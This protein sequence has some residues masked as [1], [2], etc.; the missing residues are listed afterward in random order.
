M[1]E[2]VVLAHAEIPWMK[3][4]AIRNIVAHQYFDV[5]PEVLWRS[6]TEDLP[7]LAGLL[8][9]LLDSE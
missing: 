6:A 2:E 9:R 8:R 5:S 4:R 7:I 3:M 1:P